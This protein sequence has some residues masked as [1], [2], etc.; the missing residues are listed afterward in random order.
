MESNGSA[1]RVRIDVWADVVCPACYLADNRLH[2]AIAESGH[3][4]RIDLVLHAFELHPDTPDEVA[5]NSDVLAKMMG[6]SREQ[7]EAGERRFAEVAAADGLAFSIERKHRN[8]RTM[9]RVLKLAQEY[10]V[11]TALMTELQARAFRGD[12][13][14]FDHETLETA[15]VSL[16]IPGERVR[17]VV[18][19]DEFAAQ[20]DADRRIAVQMGARGVP[21]AVF[22]GRFALPGAATVAGYRDAIAHAFAGETPR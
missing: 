5:D 8:T 21:F 6:A 18:A 19:T 10:D 2:T 17:E 1:Q 15:A 7:V 20:I 11:A 13:D 12:D 4:D 22:D 14:A 9:H 16:G 3:A